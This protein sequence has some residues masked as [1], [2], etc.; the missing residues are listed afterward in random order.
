MT[1]SV[2]ISSPELSELLKKTSEEMKID[3]S[4]IYCVEFKGKQLMNDASVAQLKQ[5][6]VLEVKIKT[7]VDRQ[8]KVRG[9]CTKCDCV[10]YARPK[11]GNDC[12]YCKD[13]VV[14]HEAK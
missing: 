2:K 3:P 7:S 6:D 14:H 11:E 10:S 13:A 5:G 1:S 4:L 9:K 12:D 8:K